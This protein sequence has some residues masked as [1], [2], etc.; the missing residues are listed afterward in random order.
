[1][2]I[3]ITKQKEDGGF[4]K[5]SLGLLILT[6]IVTKVIEIKI[7]M[8]ILFL[9]L[10]FGGILVYKKKVGQELIIAFLFAMI[11]TSYYIYEY[12]T[13]NLFL[14]RVNLFPLVSWIFGLVLFREIYERFKLKYKKII[15]SI[16]YITFL[17][18]LEY[19]GYN[20][21]NIQLTSSFPGLFG[22]NL[23]HSPIGMKL[24]YLFA[25]P[26]YLLVTDYLK[27]K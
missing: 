12:T 19:I 5:I 4:I 17:L 27:V 8:I 22:M 21:L 6:I 16:I 13:L 18:F 9:L 26:V 14:G 15:F 10:L 23:I 25:G 11:I 2:E 24:F 1:M 3:K 20:Y 7:A